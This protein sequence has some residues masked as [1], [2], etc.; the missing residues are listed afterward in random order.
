MENDPPARVPDAFNMDG[1]ADVVPMWVCER[2][3]ADQSPAMHTASICRDV[4]REREELRFLDGPK[5]RRVVTPGHRERKSLLKKSKTSLLNPP[6][7]SPNRPRR[8]PAD[9]VYAWF[10]DRTNAVSG[11]HMQDQPSAGPCRLARYPVSAA[12][13]V[14]SSYTETLL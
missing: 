3:V 5:H 14:S 9:F 4:L 13:R 10:H 7:Y 11:S 6:R 12:G 1:A 8:I 2:N